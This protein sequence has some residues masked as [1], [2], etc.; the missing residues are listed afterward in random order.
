MSFPNHPDRRLRLAPALLLF[1]LTACVPGGVAGLLPGQRASDPPPTVTPSVTPSPTPAPD[2]PIEPAW[3]SEQEYLSGGEV[4]GDRVLVMAPGEAPDRTDLAA[5]DKDT[6]KELWR[7]PWS[8]HSGTES[9]KV[10]LVKAADQ[11]YAVFVTDKGERGANYVPYQ[12]LISVRLSDGETRTVIEQAYLRYIPS[13]CSVGSDRSCFV[14]Q[15]DGFTEWNWVEW[16]PADGQRTMSRL[17][18]PMGHVIGGWSHTVRDNG[19]DD[20]NEQFG[21]VRDGRVQWLV[22]SRQ[23]LGSPVGSFNLSQKSGDAPVVIST[24]DGELTDLSAAR[25]VALRPQDGGVVWRRDGVFG[26]AAYIDVEEPATGG[27]LS[28][29]EGAGKIGEPGS[30]MALVQIDRETGRTLRGFPIDAVKENLEEPAERPILP[31]HHTAVTKDG[32]RKVL[33]TR[34]G[35]TAD[36]DLGRSLCQVQVRRPHRFYKEPRLIGYAVKPCQGEDRDRTL[37]ANLIDVQGDKGFATALRGGKVYA[38][39]A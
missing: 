11:Y 37:P 16:A 27:P 2:R 28:R 6:G 22:D 35:E 9:G 21:L 25:L 18:F 17:A 7:R 24:T 20:P 8:P 14:A 10:G 5:L 29:C 4:I 36:L 32:R 1:L 3:V 19:T 30:V 13:I 31:L 33:D 39:R 26:C 15:L 12:D 23:T 38:Y 34:S